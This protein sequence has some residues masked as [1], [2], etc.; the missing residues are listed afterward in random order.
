MSARPGPRGGYHVSGIP[1]AISQSGFWWDALCRRLSAN[2]RNQRP[3]CLSPPI[4][5]HNQ[6]RQNCRPRRICV[7][8]QNC[9][10]L[11]AIELI[12]RE[13]KAALYESDVAA[14]RKRV[15][16]KACQKPRHAAP[17][18]PLNPRRRKHRRLRCPQTHRNAVT[19][20]T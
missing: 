16:A 3:K 20:V 18:K 9:V 1:T 6:R 7:G 12:E 15:M 2:P 11:Y 10:R 8:S 4:P 13:K 14:T 17:C 19:S 5:A